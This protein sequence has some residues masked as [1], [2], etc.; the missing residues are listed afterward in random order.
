LLPSPARARLHPNGLACL[1]ITLPVP[2][3]PGVSKHR[4]FCFLEKSIIKN[5]K[6]HLNKR[7]NKYV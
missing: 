7:K 6:F 5:K 2:F 1:P 4:V 3:Q